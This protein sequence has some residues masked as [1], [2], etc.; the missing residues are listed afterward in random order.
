MATGKTGVGVIGCGFISDI[1]LTVCATFDALEVRGCADVVRARAEAQ[2]AKHGIRAYNVDE[3]LADPDVE[4]VLNLTI[5]QAHAAVS[6]QALAAGKS[7]YSEKPLAL[8]R[9][10][11]QALLAE[12]RR[13]GLRVG[14][15]PDTFLGAGL[16]TCRKLIDDGWIG[17]P[18]AAT[19]FMLGHGPE[20]WHPDP[21]FFYPPGA[22]PLFDMGPYYLTALVALLGP[23]GRVSSSARISV[24]ERTMGSAAR[25]G[26]RIA[27]NTPTHVAAIL[28]FAAGPVATLVTSFD[29]WSATVPRLE[30]YGTDGSLVLPDPNTF[31]GPVL[32]R[33]AG[34]TEWSPVPLTHGYS[35]N[36][37]GLGVADMAR[38]IQMGR[39]HRASGELAY[40]VLDVMQSI[41][42]AATEGR[43]RDIESACERP[44]PLPLGLRP[45]EIDA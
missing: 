26:E 7:V 2:A 9:E 5:P 40:H 1:Y 19:G 28:D 35:E 16:Q 14:A 43:R 18:V 38:A 20:G 11:G 22:G 39:P 41:L 23:V 25:R 21:D 44:A 37:R 33:R 30:I 32:V 3:L 17:E 4:I 27:V 8:T 13:R 31:G 42:D 34:A 10:D 36:S 29:V 6:A 24:P 45:G 12:A 15:A